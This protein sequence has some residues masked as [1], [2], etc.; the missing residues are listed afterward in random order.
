MCKYFVEIE[1]G[2]ITNTKLPKK[3]NYV[4]CSQCGLV[5]YKKQKVRVI[6]KEK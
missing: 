6:K 1:D 4:L 2:K 3:G 5:K